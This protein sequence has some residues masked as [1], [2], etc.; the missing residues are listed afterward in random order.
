MGQVLRSNYEDGVTTYLAVLFEATSLS[1]FIDRAD[2]IQM[3]VSNHGKLQEEIIKLKE[4]M[5]S[6][7]GLI[8]E[9]K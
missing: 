9:K 3:I 7:M 4:T 5:N 6:Q 2:K 1:D 8:E